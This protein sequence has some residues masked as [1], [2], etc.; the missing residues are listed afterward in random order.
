VSLATPTLPPLL[1]KIQGSINGRGSKRLGVLPYQ[2]DGSR[3]ARV[4]WRRCYK[5]PPTNST[6]PPTA[7][8]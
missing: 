3:S 8:I 6:F 4:F 2:R 7:S 5:S 1:K